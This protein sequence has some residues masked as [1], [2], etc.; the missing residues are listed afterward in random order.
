MS[1][2]YGWEKFCK[3]IEG[4]I[5]ND[6]SLQKR[7]ADA[8]IYRLIHVGEPDV[9]EEVWVE[10][11]KLGRAVTSKSAVGNEGSVVASTCIMADE[12]AGKWLERIVFMFSDV[13]RAYGVE[14]SRFEKR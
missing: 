12:E 10:L 6:Q 14:N 3:A 4:A 11:K 2:S 1:L 5:S 13:A 8:Y 9:P 7:L